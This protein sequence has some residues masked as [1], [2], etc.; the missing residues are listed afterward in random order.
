MHLLIYCHSIKIIP[1][2]RVGSASR[3]V[4]SQT[5]CTM[6]SFGFTV[7]QQWFLNTWLGRKRPKMS[8]SLMSFAYKAQKWRQTEKRRMV[9]NSQVV[10][11][12]VSGQNHA[13]VICSMYGEQKWKSSFLPCHLTRIQGPWPC[14][15]L[16]LPGTCKT[17]DQSLLSG[18]WK[19][20]AAYSIPQKPQLLL[21]ARLFV[22]CYY[23]KLDITW[24]SVR[25]CLRWSP[26]FAL[27]L[28]LFYVTG[29]PRGGRGAIWAI[30]AIIW[31][32]KSSFFWSGRTSDKKRII[33]YK[34]IHI[35]IYVY[36]YM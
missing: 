9:D 14:G 20:A 32:R 33:R 4:S 19:C 13:H 23:Q 34:D 26:Q 29:L 21:E 31:G 5:Y 27:V 16:P 18:S 10:P 22:F 28:G 11:A 7:A 15:P 24:L 3:A 17:W 6:F 25:F 1:Q 35:Y 2:D 36:I 30:W 8:H 12:H